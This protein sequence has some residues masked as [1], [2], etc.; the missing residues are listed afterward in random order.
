MAFYCLWASCTSD[1]TIRLQISLL[2]T[3]SF[4]LNLYQILLEQFE[5]KVIE[6]IRIEVASKI[7]HSV[8]LTIFLLFSGKYYTISLNRVMI[9]HNFYCN[10]EKFSLNFCLDFQISKSVYVISMCA[11]VPGKW[12]AKKRIINQTTPLQADCVCCSMSWE[13]GF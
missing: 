12:I 9:L 7:S 13:Q 10:D 4:L 5:T 3:Y 11:S 1:D 8:H 2:T 6:P